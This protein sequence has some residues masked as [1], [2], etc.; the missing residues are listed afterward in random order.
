M[1]AG[2]ALVLLLTASGPAPASNTNQPAGLSSV[3]GFDN[4]CARNVAD[5]LLAEWG[6]AY[7][8]CAHKLLLVAPEKASC[9]C[10]KNMKNG[11][12]L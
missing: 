12:I 5:A 10:I 6:C 11:T 1:G 9:F 4:L 3:V 7:S 2:A 8:D